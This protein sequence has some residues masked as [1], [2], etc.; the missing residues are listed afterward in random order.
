VSKK[1]KI[2]I[3]TKSL[4]ELLEFDTEDV[5]L[6][7]A[8]SKSFCFLVGLELRYGDSAGGTEG[9][10]LG[11]LSK[12]FCFLVGLEVKYGDSEGG[13]EGA[14]LGALTNSFCFLVGLEVRGGDGGVGV[15][16]GD[17]RRLY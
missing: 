16:G 15:G 3:T 4:K 5:L 9:A 13:T 12:S 1:E 2:N 10:L 7:G 6:L 17:T 14:L 11:A 8:L